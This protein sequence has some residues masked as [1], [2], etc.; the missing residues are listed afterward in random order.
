MHTASGMAV[1]TTPASDRSEAAA[2]VASVRARVAARV[3]RSLR[4]RTVAW[5]TVGFATILVM[6]ALAL[7]AFVYQQRGVDAVRHTVAVDGRLAR[8]LSAVQDAETGQRG[9]LLT[10]DAAFLLPF[11]EGRLNADRQLDRLRDL[12]QDDPD[13]QVDLDA[14]A[15]LIARSSTSSAPASPSCAAATARR[16]APPWRAGAASR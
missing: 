10:G 9:Y 8:V 13:Q 11:T 1:S 12:V 16:P 15:G 5:M 3:Q 7:G 2:D 14:L 6:T 4:S